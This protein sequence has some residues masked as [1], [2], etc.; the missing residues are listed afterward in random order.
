MSWANSQLKAEEGKPHN[1]AQ[2]A[3]GI[4]LSGMSIMNVAKGGT[5][6]AQTLETAFVLLG[7]ESRFGHRHVN[8]VGG[9]QQM[10]SRSF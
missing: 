7:H 2:H 8:H 4:D 5:H 10:S 1:S 3:W 9:G 6:A